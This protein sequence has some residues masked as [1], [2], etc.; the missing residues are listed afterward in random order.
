MFSKKILLFFLG[1]YEVEIEGMYIQRF[2][3]LAASKKIK[4]I[5]S[6]LSKGTVLKF[7]CFVKDIEKVKEIAKKTDCLIDIKKE[8]GLPSFINRYKK[9][10]YFIWIFLITFVFLFINSLFIWNIDINEV[11]N[12]IIEDREIN[13][14]YEILENNGVKVG[15]IKNNFYDRKESII[16]KIAAINWQFFYFEIK[17]LNRIK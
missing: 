15:K 5:S 6:V 17:L 12:N 10:V 13:I 2:I 14:I 4:I 3:N 9:R 1:F 16:N 7:R 11:E 8:K